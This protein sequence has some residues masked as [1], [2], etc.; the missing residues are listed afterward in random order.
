VSWF[1]LSDR[2][3]VTSV[4]GKGRKTFNLT[5]DL[6]KPSTEA[7]EVG[8]DV[9]ENLRHVVGLTRYSGDER[10]ERSIGQFDGRL[11]LPDN[12]LL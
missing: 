12:P 7:A 10:G 8:E 1:P 9:L 6:L 5:R 2:H 3:S 4:G 11:D